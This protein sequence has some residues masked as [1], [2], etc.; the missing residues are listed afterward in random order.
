MRI[1][2]DNAATTPIAPEVQE[3]MIAALKDN[4]GNPSSVHA[5][6]R[7]ARA[8]IEIARKIVAKTITASPGEIFFTSGG[9]ESHNT[10]LNGAI[11]DLGVKR[12]ITSPLEHPCILHPLEQLKEK[13]GIQVDFVNVNKAG[14]VDIGHLK[15]LL[16]QNG[17][18]TMVSLMHSNNEIGTMIDLDEIAGICEQYSALFHTD[19]VQTIGYFPI[20]V[21]KT[22]IHFLAGSA[23]KFHGPKGVGFLYVNLANKIS[24]FLTGGGQ[25]RDMRS[26]TENTIGIVGLAKALELAI[27]HMAENK[28]HI[29]Q[30]KLYLIEQLQ[31]HFEDIQFNGDIADRHHYKVLSVSFPESKRS[32][33][34][35]MNLDIAGISVSGGSA[36]SSGIERG[37]PVL[38]AIGSPVERKTIRFSFSKYNNLGEIDTVVTELQ[39]LLKD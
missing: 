23:H 1:Y 18:K 4:F 27:S 38:T 22:K 14:H 17:D 7:N 31:T 16:A 29:E 12:I 8:A 32:D 39:R 3:V 33:T 26:G 6:G 37:S 28:K 36:C 2:F 10:I 19:T 9:T 21:S 20:D 30:L 34:L 5:E 25:E 35:V 11:N 24:P 13:Y 15:Q